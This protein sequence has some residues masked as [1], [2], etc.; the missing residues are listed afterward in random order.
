MVILLCIAVVDRESRP[1][2]GGFFVSARHCELVC[3]DVFFIHG[4]VMYQAVTTKTIKRDNFVYFPCTFDDNSS[5]TSDWTIKSVIKNYRGE[6]IT[7]LTVQ[8]IDDN[9]GTYELHL[10][11]GFVLPKDTLYFDVRMTKDGKSINNDTIKLKVVDV[12]T[13]GDD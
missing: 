9:A 5:V 3:S 1:F 10:P 8:N 11:E 2:L 6:L 13:E 4:L 12:V 7:T